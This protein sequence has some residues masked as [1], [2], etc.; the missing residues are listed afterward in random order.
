[1]AQSF[2]PQAGTIPENLPRDPVR[3]SRFRSSKGSH[4]ARRPNKAR[5][6]GCSGP[7]LPC[8]E[9]ARN[10]AALPYHPRQKEAPGDTPGLGK[11][12]TRL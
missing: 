9:G 7:A 8:P 3:S 5:F 10:A 4:A 6:G 2:G 12:T 11:S 1:M